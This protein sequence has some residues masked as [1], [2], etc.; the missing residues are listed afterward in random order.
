[1]LKP[2]ARFLIGAPN[3]DKKKKK[4][5]KKKNNSHCLKSESTVGRLLT[6]NQ[7]KFF[8]V[9]NKCSVTSLFLIA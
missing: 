2:L 8:S 4:K 3:D 1:M 7:A 6:A 9:C 5:E